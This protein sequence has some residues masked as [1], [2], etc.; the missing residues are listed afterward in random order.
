[1]RYSD[2]KKVFSRKDF[3]NPD[4]FFHLI[5]MSFPACGSQVCHNH[6][7]GQQR[8]KDQNGF[9]MNFSGQS[10]VQNL[11]LAHTFQLSTF[12]WATSN[13]KVGKKC[14]LLM[15]RGNKSPTSQSLTQNLLSKIKFS[16]GSYGIGFV[17]LNLPWDIKIV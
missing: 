8:R 12:S 5:D 17:R 7:S 4:S 10:W 13:L 14:C 1:M 6:L 3:V 15:C 2:N 16:V 9:Y 11:L